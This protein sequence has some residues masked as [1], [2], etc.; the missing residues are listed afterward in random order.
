MKNWFISLNG[1]LIITALAIFSE[2]WRAFLDAMFVF[3]VNFPDPAMG[4]IAALVFAILFGGWTLALAFAW[5][6]SRKALITTFALNLLVLFVIPISWL[7]FYC[8]AVCQ[9]DAGIFNLANTLN[10][11]LGMLAAIAL[12]IQIRRPQTRMDTIT[13]SKGELDAI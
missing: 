4:Q 7:F 12:G 3:P 2:A 5:R 13:N 8:P 6:G 10:L 11:I 9:A 1:A